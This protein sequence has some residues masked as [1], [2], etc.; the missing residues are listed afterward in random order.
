MKN[1]RDGE[2]LCQDALEGAASWCV[3][4]A[5]QGACVLFQQG[6]VGGISLGEQNLCSSLSPAC[7]LRFLVEDEKYIPLLHSVSLTLLFFFS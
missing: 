2:V 1:A 4:P 7:F 5:E 3:L 6:F